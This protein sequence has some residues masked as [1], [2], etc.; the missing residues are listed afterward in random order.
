[1]VRGPM[2][3]KN[4]RKNGFFP[5]PLVA[6]SGVLLTKKQV[7]KMLNVS[8]STIERSMKSRKIP[9]YLL[10]GIVRF[11][12]EKIDNWIKMKQVRQKI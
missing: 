11:D 2:H 6:M 7:A 5:R 9:Y 1:M 12:E 10:N 4:T 8:Q 3:V